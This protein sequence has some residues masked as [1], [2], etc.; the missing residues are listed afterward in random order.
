MKFFRTTEFF[1]NGIHT[2]KYYF[3]GVRYLKKIWSD[4]FRETWIL[5]FRTSHT[6][7]NY[8]DFEIKHHPIS[9][10]SP[11][12]ATDGISIVEIGDIS[13]EG[14]TGRSAIE[15]LKHSDINF[16]YGVVG[17]LYNQYVPKYKKQLVFSTANF[18]KSSAYDIIPLLVWEF[19]S[20][21][22][23]ARPYAFNNI[24]GIA[25]FSTFCAKYFGNLFRA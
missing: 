11:Q 13:G 7:C 21:M 19:E 1:D 16:D 22:T 12:L 4:T 25:T 24:Y 5:K 6:K 8:D 20:G 17:D 14:K 23:D 9:D 18:A 15:S 3:C 2:K 10:K